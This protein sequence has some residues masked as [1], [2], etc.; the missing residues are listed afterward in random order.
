MLFYL[1]RIAKLGCELTADE[2]HLLCVAS[3]NAIGARQASW[4][5]ISCIQERVQ[6]TGLKAHVPTVALY[7]SKLEDQVEKLCRQ[8]LDILDDLLLANATSSEAIVF[9]YKMKGDCNRY[10]AEFACGDKRM[11]A[12]TAAQEAYNHATNIAQSQLS[13]IEPI[14]L[15]LA[16]N[17]AVF[18]YQ[19]LNSPKCAFEM[20]AQALD[21]AITGLKTVSKE[22]NRDCIVI[23]QLLKDNLDL[24]N[25]S[26]GPLDRCAE[27]RKAI[28]CVRFS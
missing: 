9:Y 11:T 8:V 21:D 23:M 2:R 20:A 22:F 4:R 28:R 15:R 19:T 18:H 27:G 17:F 24:W 13:P 10:L 3:K 25:D 14:R 6:F 7:R 26:D 5:T 16:L 12:A 1:A